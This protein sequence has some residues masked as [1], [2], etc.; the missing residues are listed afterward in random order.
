MNE[1][2]HH[3]M[4]GELDDWPLVGLLDHMNQCG[5]SVI[6]R[7]DVPDGV[8]WIHVHTGEIYRCTFD[9]LS[10]EKALGALLSRRWG[11]FSVKNARHLRAGMN[12]I[13]PSR[14]LLLKLAFEK[15]YAASK[16]PVR[17]AA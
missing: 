13:T 17:V 8:G 1:L 9:D 6:V 4:Q 11:R 7:V 2:R 3:S 12:I 14:L 15:D 10:G 5:R 16:Q